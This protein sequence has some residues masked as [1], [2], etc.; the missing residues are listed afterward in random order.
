M[1]KSEL[2]Q[3]IREEISKVLNE[4]QLTEWKK[5]TVDDLVHDTKVKI[6]R[7]RHAG[8][9][10]TIHDFDLTD[11]GKLVDDQIDILVDK[12]GKPRAYLG[13]DDI[14]VETINR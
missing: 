6:V 2:R 10:G 1:K 13:L 7:G 14:M 11:G 3:L 12:P 4:K 8:S 9:I 5:A